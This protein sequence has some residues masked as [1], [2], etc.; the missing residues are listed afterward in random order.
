MM[1]SKSLK[2][3]SSAEPIKPVP[4]DSCSLHT[5]LSS[6]PYL[7]SRDKF[8]SFLGPSV[9][10]LHEVNS[11]L[12]RGLPRGLASLVNVTSCSAEEPRSGSAANLSESSQVVAT[13]RWR[14]SVIEELCYLYLDENPSRFGQAKLWQLRDG[15]AL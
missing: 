15:E 14:C 11:C 13:E 5:T 10:L 1:S 9:F 12:F 2:S 6:R 8:S 3:L 4:R 7:F